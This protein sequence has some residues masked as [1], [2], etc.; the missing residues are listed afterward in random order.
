MKK[1]LVI[2]F[3]TLLIISCG[4]SD[5]EKKLEQTRIEQGGA[6]L[7]KMRNITRLR[8]DVLVRLLQNQKESEQYVLKSDSAGLALISINQH[9]QNLSAK[10]KSEKLEYLYQLGISYAKK[11]DSID[12]VIKAQKDTIDGYDLQYK[13]TQ[14]SYVDLFTKL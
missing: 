10:E 13:I 2:P 5:K 8:N 3:L 12:I 1:L 9:P 6:I 4:Q 11:R 7:E 14:N